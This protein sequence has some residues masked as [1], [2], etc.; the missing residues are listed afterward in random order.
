MITR[1]DRRRLLGAGLLAAVSGVPVARAAPARAYKVLHV[2]SYRSDWQWNKDQ[3]RGFTEGLAV[4][5]TEIQVV[6]LD[7]KRN[8]SVALAASARQADER[9]SRWKPDLIYTNDDIAQSAFAVRHLDTATPIVFSGVNEEPATYGFDRAR[10]V[11]GVL[12]REHFRGTL[13]LLRELRP[14]ARLRL[15]IVVDDDPTWVGVTARIRAEL[16][17]RTDVQVLHW[18]QPRTLAEYQTRMTELQTQVD[19]V[20][21]LGVFRFRLSG[22]GFADYEQVLRWTAEH[23][24]LPDFSFWDTRVERGT[25][26]AVTVDGVEQGRLAGQ[27]ARRIL[28]DG[29]APH[30]LPPQPSTRG[31]PMVSLARARALGL[32]VRADVL[33]NTVVLPRYAWAG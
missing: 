18:L 22:G 8:D 4:P 31:R 27:L 23:S 24:R 26:C 21:L 25:L 29:E 2:M 6:E 28:V 17:T 11:T 9:V 5:G 20:G 32:E 10:N 7:A 3:L 30:R 16:A 1:P 15:A 33:L 12:E 19:A 13:N 14:M